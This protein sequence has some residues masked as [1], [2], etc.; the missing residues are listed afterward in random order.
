MSE[1]V[2]KTDD[3]TF[4][5]RLARLQEFSSENAEKYRAEIENLLLHRISLKDRWMYGGAA[6]V[7]GG[8]LLIGG[9]AIALLKPHQES[10]HF[11]HARITFGVAC[12]ASGLLLGGWVLYIAI[13]GS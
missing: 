13:K 8:A 2:F 5:D 4:G 9:I 6:L 10:M 3:W 1:K 12:A 7:G 11:S